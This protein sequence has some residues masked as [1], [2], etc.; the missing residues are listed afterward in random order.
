[1]K[2]IRTKRAVVIVLIVSVLCFSVTKFVQNNPRPENT[3]I[4][5]QSAI[6]NCDLDAFL[7]CIDSKWSNQI[8]SICDFTVRERKS[9]VSS[10]I[11]LIKTIMPILP[12][13]SVGTI[14]PEDF[15]QV[16]FVILRTDIAGDAAVVDLSGLLTCG[17]YH[18]PFATTVEMRLRNNMWIISGIR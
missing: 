18:K 6:N 7:N 15:P 8:E 3:I 13:S 14:D 11:A 1:M 17:D 5:L 9:S 10:F 16:D 2:L 4:K 12:F